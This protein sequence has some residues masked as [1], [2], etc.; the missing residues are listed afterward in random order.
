MRDRRRRGECFTG[1]TVECPALT[2]SAWIGCGEPDG[3]VLGF[4]GVSLAVVSLRWIVTC[5]VPGF[6][7]GE[8]QVRWRIPS[9]RSSEQGQLTGLT[10]LL[11]VS[12]LTLKSDRRG[13]WWT[14]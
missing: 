3:G 14:R 13:S 10:V 9:T 7:T 12:H 5:W 4:N 2:V 11:I 8:K 6:P 1:L